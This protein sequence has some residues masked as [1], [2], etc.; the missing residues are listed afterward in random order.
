MTNLKVPC[1]QL[2]LAVLTVACLAA[3]ASAQTYTDLH[4][5]DETEGCCALQPSMLTQGQDG[6]IYG[7]TTSG[8][9]HFYGNVFK[10][11]P[12]GTLTS[13]YS[14][15]LTHG[16]YPQGGISMA[17]DGNFYGTT[18]QGGTNHFGT[19]FKVTSSGA[20]T[21]L[22][23][24]N[25]TNDGAY[26]HTPPVQA[27]DG[28]LYGTTANGTVAVL[29]KIT[30]AGVFTVME[31]LAGQSY[32]PLLLG[33]DGNLYGTTVYG[34]TYNGG[35]VF[36]F[37]PTA[38]AIKTIY[39]FHTEWSPYGPLIQGADGA[40]YGTTSA[41]GTGS[42]GVIFRVTT[43][44]VYKVLFNFSSSSSA[45]GGTS[46]SGLVQGSDKFLYGV[47]SGGGANGQG[48]LFKIGPTGT[49]FA[50]LHSFAT[51]TGD[52][53][54][55]TPFLHSNG[56]I[57][58]LTSH[59]GA[60]SAYGVVYSM[61][62][63]LK[64]FV[65]PVVLHS[66]RSNTSV[67][68]L[69]QGFNTATGV[70]FGTGAGTLTVSSDTFATAK[71]TTG[72]TTGAITVKEPGGNLSTLQAFK[73]V[74]TIKNF[75]P[76]S[77]TVGTSVVITGTSLLQTLTVKFNGVAA[78]VFTVNSDTQVTATVPAGAVTGKITITTNGG[79]AASSAVFTVD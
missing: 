64:E 35:T 55:A 73:I 16:G 39:N 19:I 28:N 60:N 3:A 40:L 21:E 34:G 51:A 33:A 32:S 12:S 9:S 38:K 48:V 26:P 65:A 70:L 52:T 37:S 49:G 17:A 24:F 45:N 31:T 1:H 79:T 74:P 14:F 76:T 23:D 42:W 13:I 68:L 36:V 53:P 5:F 62:V 56:T 71:I 15:D 46:Y 50:A 4:D 59:G 75:N 11:T 47:T 43:A 61:N 67:E 25:N 6:N 20:F 41:G 58:G 7:A 30:T 8:G 63:S 22:Y 18:Y 66:A 54:L 27:Q 57:Y 10:M 77:G 2:L 29:Y 44:G 78:T 69:G 72:A